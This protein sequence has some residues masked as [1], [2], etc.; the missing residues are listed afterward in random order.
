[1]SFISLL[2]YIAVIYIRP[3]D[4]IPAFYGKQLLDWLAILTVFF[5]AI[6]AIGKKR[7]LILNT[8]QSL[9]LL[10]FLVTI[11]LSH[12][13]RFYFWGAYDS[14]INFSK[15]VIMFLLFVNVLDSEK[16]LKVSLWLIVILTVILAIQGIRQFRTGF[17]WAGQPLTRDGR[18]TWVGIFNDPNDLAL[19]L[20]VAMGILLAFIFG[21]TKLFPKIISIPLLGILLYALYLTNSRGGYLAFAGTILFYFLRKF[22]K[23]SLAISLGGILLLLIFLLGPSRLSAIS[24]SE[25][26]AYGRIDAWYEGFQMMKKAPLFGVGYGMFTEDYHLTA[27]NSFILVAAEEGLVGLFLWI[28]LIYSCFKGLF[29]LIKNNQSSRPYLSGLEAS[30]FGFLCASYFL[31]RSYTTIPYIMFALATAFI[32]TLLKKE[33]YSFGFKDLKFSGVLSMAIL[34]ITW[35]AM[36]ISLKM[37]G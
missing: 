29:I 23:K 19:G 12:L 36:R 34:F 14:F 1:M 35:L 17:G 18:I 33:D 15:I 2:L 24:I 7:K 27:H 11:A 3:A 37:L 31:S 26:S 22:R 9:L 30:L 32:Y 6:E 10:G 4:W 16:K 28:A 8:P 21:N 13:S 20:V 25:D 5:L